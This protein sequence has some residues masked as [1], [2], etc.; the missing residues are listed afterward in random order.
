MATDLAELLRGKQPR[1]VANRET[2]EHFSWTAPRPV[3][4]PEAL[5][6]LRQNS[7]PSVTDLPV[8]SEKTSSAAKAPVALARSEEEGLLSGLKNTFLGRRP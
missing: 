3:P 2:L 4:S 6:R 1:N 8:D 5:A 7:R